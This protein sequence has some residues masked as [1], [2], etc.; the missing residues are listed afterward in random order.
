MDV[1]SRQIEEWMVAL[2]HV[3]LFPT[4]LAGDT[5]CFTKSILPDT[6][7]CLEIHC[8]ACTVQCM[9]FVPRMV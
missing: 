1:N 4:L 2:I 6:I 8:T 5:E 7:S 9:L 3:Y